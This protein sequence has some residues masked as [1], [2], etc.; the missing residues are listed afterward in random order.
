M[1]AL[2]NETRMVIGN[3]SVLSSPHANNTMDFIT[4]ASTGNAVD[5]G[6]STNTSRGKHTTGSA[7]RGLFA[8]GHSATNVIDFIQIHTTG[9]AVDYGDLSGSGE[10]AFGECGYGNGV[11]GVLSTGSDAPN[12]SVS[13]LTFVNISTT[14]NSTDYGELSSTKQPA[15]SFSN[16]TRG[17]NCCS[18]YPANS[19][20]IDA[21]EI[22][23]GG[24]SVDFG[25]YQAA[26]MLSAAMGTSN[27]HGG[28]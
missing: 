18:S 8:G 2:S 15:T 4:I 21:N 28:L 1:S 10:A 23:T 17:L 5:F 27:D 3:G 24:K 6:D 19:T 20:Q 9:N 7:T 14:G 25:D 11:R 12:Y 13:D 26:S 22:M 16:K